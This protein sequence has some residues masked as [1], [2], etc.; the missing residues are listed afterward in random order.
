V[1]DGSRK[2]TCVDVGQRVWMCEPSNTL[3]PPS[4][5]RCSMG[6]C[7]GC[8]ACIRVVMKSSWSWPACP[9]FR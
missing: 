1:G 9:A 2:A 5:R 4:K 6:R 8:G 7:T 3:S